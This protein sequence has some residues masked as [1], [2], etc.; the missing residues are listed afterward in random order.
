MRTDIHARI[1]WQLHDVAC[2]MCA[3]VT[4]NLRILSRVFVSN[5]VVLVSDDYK[6]T[7]VK[8]SPCQQYRRMSKSLR[9]LSR[10][11]V[12]DIVVPVSD[13]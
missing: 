9:L 3:R 7:F 8:Q 12:I 6:I 5:F 10:T 13:K 11:L 2:T 1:C 4:Q